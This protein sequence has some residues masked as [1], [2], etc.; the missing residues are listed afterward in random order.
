MSIKAQ[1][2][3]FERHKGKLIVNHYFKCDGCDEIHHN[4]YN[5]FDEAFRGLRET[6]NHINKSNDWEI[7]LVDGDL[8]G[9][10]DS[11]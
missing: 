4:R 8:V 9:K 3:F 7:S 2:K 11:Q 1:K 6:Y 5:G 10:D